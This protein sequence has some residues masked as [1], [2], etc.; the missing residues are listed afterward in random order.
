VAKKRNHPDIKR[1]GWRGGRRVKS[2]LS[3]GYLRKD[4]Y[5]YI[6]M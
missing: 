4:I 3:T 1:R 2:S 6:Y 5:I